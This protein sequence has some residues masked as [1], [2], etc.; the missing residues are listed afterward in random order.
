MA[1]ASDTTARY[2]KEAA[3]NQLRFAREQFDYYRPI[4]DKVSGA[5]LGLMDEQLRQGQDHYN[6]MK[7]NY[8]PLEDKM[9]QRT[10][11]FNS[12][13]YREQ[14]ARQAAAD[15]GQAFKNTQGMTERAMA[16][17]GVNPN[18]GRFAGANKMGQLGLAANR[19]NAMTGS[20]ER[21]EAYGDAMLTNAVGVGRGLVGAANGAY[22]MAL[23]AGNSAG[24]NSMAAGSNLFGQMNQAYGLAQNGQQ[25]QLNG[26]GQIMQTQGSIYANQSDPWMQALGM[27]LGMASTSK[28]WT[29]SD[30]RLKQ[31]IV[32][33]GVYPNG[34][35]AYEFAYRECPTRRFIGVMADDVEQLIPEAVTEVGGYKVVNYGQLGITMR[36]VTHA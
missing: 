17:M 36:E 9:I 1:A 5:Q 10:R 32:Q 8:R 26:L 19:A 30:R 25:M 12:D 20:R 33:V 14:L 4:L 34:L 15:A 23:N 29:G 3:D 24:Q 27:G 13:A 31:D 16:S 11:D 22:G 2:G 28:M 18:S 6:Y 35:P 21:S 7:E